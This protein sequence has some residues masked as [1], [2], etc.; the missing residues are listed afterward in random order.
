MAT[1]DIE[2]VYLPD[3]LSWVVRI[4]GE[5]VQLSLHTDKA[6]AEKRGRVEAQ[7]RGVE[8]IVKNKDGRVAKRDSHGKDRKD[9][10]G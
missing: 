6:G 8:L 9:R 1:S 2:V 10:K 5:G 3:I 7:R 4:Q